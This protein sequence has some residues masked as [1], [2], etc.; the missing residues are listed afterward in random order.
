MTAM[1]R[2]LVLLLAVLPLC[3]ASAWEP[4]P[5]EKYVAQIEAQRDTVPQTSIMLQGRRAAS[6]G[7]F[8]PSN[9]RVG[10]IFVPDPPSLFADYDEQIERQRI[11]SGSYSGSDFIRDTAIDIVGD[12][13]ESIF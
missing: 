13:L 2:L 3:H 9:F 11:A 12:I 10:Y 5:W 6:L 8:N 4:K 7:G 1:R